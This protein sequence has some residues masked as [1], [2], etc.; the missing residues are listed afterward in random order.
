MIQVSYYINKHY[1]GYPSKRR[2][3][4]AKLVLRVNS[5]GNSSFGALVS[6]P[7]HASFQ[8]FSMNR[9]VRKRTFWY[10]RPTKTQISL[11]IRAVWSESSLSAWRN[12]VFL[13]I[14][15]ALSEDSDQTARMRRLI[16]IFDERAYL[17]VRFWTFRL[18]LLSHPF[19]HKLCILSTNFHKID[20]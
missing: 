12:F 18:L 8:N 20:R 10:V 17:K 2:Q 14:Q 9:N 16:G 5:P 6:T 4:D 15:N 11:R 1:P 3:P 7:R 13:A 19:Q